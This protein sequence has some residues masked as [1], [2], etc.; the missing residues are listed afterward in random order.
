MTTEKMTIHKALAEL[1]IVDDRIISAI[2][3]GTYCVANKH[4]NEKIKGVPVKEY[5]GVMQGYYDKAT[6]L[7]K[8]RNAIKR[9]VVLSNATTKVSI[10][11]IEYTVAEAIEMKNHGVEFDEKILTALKKQ[12]DKAQAEI[13]KQNGDDLEKRAEQY[14][15]GIYG[16]KE[17]KTNTDD[18]EKT[19]KDFINANSYELIDPIKILDKINTLEENIALKMATGIA[20][21]CNSGIAYIGTEGSR[22]KYYA[23][24]FDYDLLELEEPFECEKYMA[25][26]DEAVKAGYKVL[27]IDSMTHEW[28]WLND[29]HD[30]MPGNSFTNWGKL[31]PRHHKFMDK[32]LNS[33][34]HIIATARGK[35]DWVLEDKNGKQ[36]PKKVG[37]GQQQDKD[38]SYEYTVS[39]MISQDTHVA[40]ADKDNTHLFDGKFE[41]LT[42]NDG[43]RLYDWANQGEAPAPKSPQPTYSE[44]TESDEDILY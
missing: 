17:G 23:N 44:V 27:I 13:L 21:K 39:L 40:S 26:I 29:V 24:E 25:A 31:K 19:K 16:S 6:D 22:N 37:M 11:G 4:S 3:G 28:K 9:A 5:E 33:P 8:R 43:E 7:I 42:E 1:K 32:V 15:I 10:N 2:N 36:V 30:K 38:I 18:F 14:V 20:K 41:V 34:I 35:D 12:Y